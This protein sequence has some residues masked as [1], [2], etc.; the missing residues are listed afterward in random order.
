[1]KKLCAALLAAGLLFTQ[2]AYASAAFKDVGR[3]YWANEEITYLT[4]KKIISGFKDQTFQPN[5]SVTKIQAMIMTAKALNLD[6]SNRPAPG[7]NDLPKSSSGYAEAAAIVDE[8]LFPKSASLKPAEPIT[9]VQMA[10]MLTAAFKWKASDSVSFKDV[11]KSFWGHPYITALAD[12]NITLGYPDGTFKPN[13]ALTRSQFSV[14]LARALNND[15]KTYTYTNTALKY[16]L[17]LP[18]Y[19]KTQVTAENKKDEFGGYA[20]HFYYN[21]TA[22]LGYKPMLATIRVIPESKLSLYKGAPYELV[23]KQGSTYYF[24]QGLS[25][26]PYLPNVNTSEAKAFERIHFKLSHMIKGLTPTS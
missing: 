19:M 26:S 4:N 12:Q 20:T 5:A 11:P 24:Y 23:K 9:R 6:L 16:K 14:F 1:M 15:Y 3:T 10:R 2:S 25:S 8:G 21:N 17:E 22:Q 7:F 13:N 18:N